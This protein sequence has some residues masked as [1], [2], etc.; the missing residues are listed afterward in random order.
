MRE[1]QS[2]RVAKERQLHANLQCEERVEKK[3]F[4]RR[5]HDEEYGKHLEETLR[6]VG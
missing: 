3:R 1:D 4:L 6:Q 5:L 2:K